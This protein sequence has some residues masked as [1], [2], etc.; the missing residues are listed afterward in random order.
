MIAEE[1]RAPASRNQENGAR[2]KILEVFDK[3]RTD[4]SLKSL[5]PTELADLEAL[6]HEK[7]AACISG[8]QSARKISSRS[9][10]KRF[11]SSGFS[12]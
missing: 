5:R 2:M 1:N 7:M 12:V 3:G 11:A 4:H 9:P 10:R 8:V 6:L